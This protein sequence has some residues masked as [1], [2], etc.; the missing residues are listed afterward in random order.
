MMVVGFSG[1]DRGQQGICKVAG[2]KRRGHRRN[3]QIKVI[4]VA[5]A[6]AVVALYGSDGQWLAGGQ[7]DKREGADNVRQA[8]DGQ[9]SENE[10]VD[11]VRQSG[12]G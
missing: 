5:A 10:G 12:S 9:H 3:N 11:D 1:G 4:A 8:G 7:H 2:E 6:A